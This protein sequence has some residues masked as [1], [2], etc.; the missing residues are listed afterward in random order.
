MNEPNALIYN[1]ATLNLDLITPSK[2]I[3][4]TNKFTLPLSETKAEFH[5]PVT[6]DKKK[7]IK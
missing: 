7:L 4:R 2:K 3:N 1:G 6:K 5:S